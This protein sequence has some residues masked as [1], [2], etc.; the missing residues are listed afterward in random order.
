MRPALT[1]RVGGRSVI[2]L[3]LRITRAE[4]A[5]TAADGVCRVDAAGRKAGNAELRGEVAL[6]SGPAAAVDEYEHAP[7]DDADRTP[8]PR[9]LAHRLS[10]SSQ[11]PRRRAQR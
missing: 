7:H 8:P 3:E 4:K 2:D 1:D 6:L 11:H 5:A 9:G 10:E